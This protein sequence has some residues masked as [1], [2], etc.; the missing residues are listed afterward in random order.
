MIACAV[1]LALR[2]LKGFQASLSPMLGWSLSGLLGT[3]FNKNKPNNFVLERTLQSL[4]VS[5]VSYSHPKKY[6]AKTKRVTIDT[7]S[8]YWQDNREGRDCS[9]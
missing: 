3:L 2:R 5:H 7:R 1:T 8:P 4:L 9:A 6:F